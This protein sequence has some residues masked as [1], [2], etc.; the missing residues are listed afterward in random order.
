MPLI[1]NRD[2]HFVSSCDFFDTAKYHIS[3]LNVKGEASAVASV[4][5]KSR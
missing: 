4:V 3:A 1:V 2:N 5:V